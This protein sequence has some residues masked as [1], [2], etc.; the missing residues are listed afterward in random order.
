[1]G[2]TVESL[3]DNISV[4]LLL[5]CLTAKEAKQYG[6]ET[7]D[8]PT[9][10]RLAAT[11]N[12]RRVISQWVLEREHWCWWSRSIYCSPRPPTAAAA[13]AAADSTAFRRRAEEVEEAEK[14]QVWSVGSREVD[15]LEVVAVDKDSDNRYWQQ[16]GLLP[17]EG[18]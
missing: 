2:P 6:M 15:D 13:A 8:W 3:N 12:K 5:A 18:G 14:A 7:R 9:N 4:K 1:M 17:R 16:T 10:T 11:P